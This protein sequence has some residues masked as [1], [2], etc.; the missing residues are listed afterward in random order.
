MTNNNYRVD[1]LGKPTIFIA[2][3]NKKIRSKRVFA[4]LASVQTHSEAL[5]RQQVQ[6]YL[7]LQEDD[8]DESVYAGRLRV[9]LYGHKQ[10]IGK[11]LDI[12]STDIAFRDKT[13]DG[14]FLSDVQIFDALVRHNTLDSLKD[15]VDLY[16]GE[17][18]E[19]LNLDNT[20]FEFQDLLL[21]QRAFW[22]N[23]VT[24][25]LDKIIDSLLTGRRKSDLAEAMYYIRKNL[26]INPMR[27][28]SQIQLATLYCKNGQR[29]HAI[30]HLENY[31][32]SL[33][34]S[35]GLV[36]SKEVLLLLETLKLQ[37]SNIVNLS[38]KDDTIH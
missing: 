21:Q 35:L 36:T 4:L 27:D 16:K 31:L 5:T 19:G 22:Q 12:S 13:D 7:W 30:A 38:S 8:Q 11:F 25:I 28:E 2:G 6:E 9:L 15:A 26:Q 17:Y 18:L 1:F 37:E 24:Q 23:K 32:A 14:E 34:E 20:S 33:N 29:S 3:K 10:F